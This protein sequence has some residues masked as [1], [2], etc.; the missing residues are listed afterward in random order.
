MGLRGRAGV[1]VLD[2]DGGGSGS[3][4][5][6]VLEDRRLVV[7]SWERCF[8]QPSLSALRS[9]IRSEAVLPCGGFSKVALGALQALAA[10]RTT[11]P[12]TCRGVMPEEPARHLGWQLVG[13]RCRSGH[14][15]AHR[16][17]RAVPDETRSDSRLLH[18]QTWLPASLAAT[19]SSMTRCSTVGC[20][21]GSGGQ[22]LNA[23]CI[24]SPRM[25]WASRSSGSFQ[26]VDRI[27]P[28]RCLGRSANPQL[29]EPEVSMGGH[30]QGG[31]PDARFRQSPSGPAKVVHQQTNG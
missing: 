27:R 3:G 17:S 18:R 15:G 11:W 21:S 25:M 12:G 2:P 24:S 16:G 29:S 13:H 20:Q 26:V 6:Q 22:E 9:H 31:L 5:V 4:L 28:T 19:D 23:W 30:Q 10:W 1:T 14:T 7:S 8:S